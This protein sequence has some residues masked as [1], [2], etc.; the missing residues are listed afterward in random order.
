MEE[1]ALIDIFREINWAI[2]APIIII[3]GILLIVS[4][5]DL[6]RIE[7]TNGPKWLWFIIVIFINIIGPIIYFIFGRRQD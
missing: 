1:V 5:I 2:I 7:K 4:V 3:Q 6:V